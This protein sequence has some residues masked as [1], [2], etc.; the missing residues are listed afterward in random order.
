MSFSCFA[1]YHICYRKRP[2]NKQ[3]VL[4][5]LVDYIPEFMS[6]QMKYKTLGK[7]LTNE[8]TET[9]DYTCSQAECHR[10]AHDSKTPEW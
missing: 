5:I 6:T 4:A 2:Q 7:L 8:V 9:G 1:D 10:I 3:Q